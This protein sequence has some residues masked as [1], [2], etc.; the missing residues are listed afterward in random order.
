MKNVSVIWVCVRVHVCVMHWGAHAH[1]RT[2]VCV[3]V[4]ACS[5]VYV[6]CEVEGGTL[7]LIHGDREVNAST[8]LGEGKQF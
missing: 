3:C 4:R 6:C 1:S 2:C 7:A 8:G 5:H